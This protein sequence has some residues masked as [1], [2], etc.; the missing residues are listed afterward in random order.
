[1]FMT[2]EL[3]IRL[4][5]GTDVA[6]WFLFHPKDLTHRSQDP[7]NWWAEDFAISKEFNAG[8]L[9]AVGTGKDGTSNVR[10][11]NRGLTERE[12]TYAKKS[13]EFRLRVQ[14]GCLYLDG[15]LALPHAGSFNPEACYAS[16]DGWI[17]LPNG[18]YRATVYAIAWFEEPHA[19]DEDGYS[20]PQALASYVVDI[21]PVASL[22][23]IRPPTSVPD[24]D[25]II[26]EPEAI[27]S[28]GDSWS[29][30]E[31]YVEP[32][33][34]EYPLLYWHEVIFPDVEQEIDLSA[35]AE[36]FE[37]KDWQVV[38]SDSIEDQA[39]GT[40]FS[41]SG[42]SGYDEESGSS[43][44]ALRGVG[45]QLVRL[46][47]VFEQGDVWWVEVEPYEPLAS[48]VSQA[49]ID[50]LKQQ[51]A[52][53]AAQDTQYQNRIEFHSF[54]A[55]RVASLTK[56]RELGWYVAHAIALEGSQQQALLSLSDAD[57][58]EELNHALE[59]RLSQ[60]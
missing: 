14:Q 30:N 42:V 26:Y 3:N 6:T 29:V 50:R 51:F 7:H 25:P 45:K 28:L 54:Y 52:D 12:Q 40:L 4:A 59:T 55:E 27:D 13:A 15:G 49:E 16:S 58:I 57:L 31:G 22:E 19:M 24:L 56:P 39:I 23:E 41:V 10:F 46:K 9:V 48:S 8:Q 36:P 35:L 34:L 21:Q 43:A 1:M 11:T 17:T 33:A 38:F 2:A 60:Y 5:V 44:Q 37:I 32:L 47:T 53:Y 20:T 18:N